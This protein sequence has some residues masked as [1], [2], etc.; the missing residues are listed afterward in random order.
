MI[1]GLVW[2]IP[3]FS[4]V[5]WLAMLL[6]MLIWWLTEG[7]PHYASMQPGQQIAYISGKRPR[8]ADGRHSMRNA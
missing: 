5:V 6:A 1:W 3:I 7:S 4:A 2:A 8:R